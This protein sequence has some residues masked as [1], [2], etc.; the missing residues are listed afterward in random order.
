MMGQIRS[1]PQDLK[2]K[3]P[4]AEDLSGYVVV[5]SNIEQDHNVIYVSGEYTEPTLVKDMKK[6]TCLL[7]RFAN[8]CLDPSQGEVLPLLNAL[9]HKICVNTHQKKRALKKEFLNAGV[10][11]VH[12]DLPAL[13]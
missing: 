11:L 5:E 13:I 7:V 4:I 10:T 3:Q 1:F 8:Y 12:L 9:R 2:H 6:Q